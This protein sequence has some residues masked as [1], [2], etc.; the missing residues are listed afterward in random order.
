MLTTGPYVKIILKVSDF[1]KYILRPVTLLIGYC[2]ENRYPMRLICILEFYLYFSL[3]FSLSLSVPMILRDSQTGSL[4]KVLVE[5]PLLKCAFEFVFAFKTRIL[6]N[7]SLFLSESQEV[8]RICLCFYL[9]ARK[10]A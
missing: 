1:W 2:D 4:P 8:F 5:A 6:L 3:S 10:S 7:L 9:R